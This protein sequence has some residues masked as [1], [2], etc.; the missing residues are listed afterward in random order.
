LHVFISMLLFLS[1]GTISFNKNSCGMFFIKDM[2][3]SQSPFLWWPNLLLLLS[4]C[5]VLH[6]CLNWGFF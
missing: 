5:C 6:E 3:F 4:F 2:F 1:S